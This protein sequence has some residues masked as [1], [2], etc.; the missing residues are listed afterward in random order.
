MRGD[1]PFVFSNRKFGEGLDAIT[2][3]IEQHGMLGSQAAAQTV[4][5]GLN[6]AY[7]FTG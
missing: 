3:F 5:A 4:I 7:R 6:F 1:R 2:R